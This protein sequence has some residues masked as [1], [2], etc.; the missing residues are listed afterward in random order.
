MRASSSDVPGTASALTLR[1]QTYC[2]KGSAS[3]KE[4]KSQEP[5]VLS[6]PCPLT[7]RLTWLLQV[8]DSCFFCSGVART[9]D[10]LEGAWTTFPVQPRP[11]SPELL[12]SQQE[13]L[14]DMQQ[15]LGGYRV[16]CGRT[17]AILMRS[18][19]ESPSLR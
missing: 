11:G 17:V 19:S 2:R 7:D 12:Q 8:R 3:V 6:R 4:R 13:G 16:G 10:A 14:K 1:N 15:V 9:S 5:G 18:G